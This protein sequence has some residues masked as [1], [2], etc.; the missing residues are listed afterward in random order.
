MNRKQNPNFYIALLLFLTII[1]S[2]L[3]VTAY[4]ASQKKTLSVSA[5]AAT[6]YVPETDDVLF[7][8]NQDLKLPMAS[9]TKIM[10][11]LVAIE[12]TS[13]DDMVRIDSS[14]VG[15]EGS[16]AYLQKGD[17]LTMEELLYALLLQ[18]ANDAAVA[19]ACYVGG[20]IDE[21]A[22]MMNEK[23]EKLE[24]KNTHFTNPH[25]LDDQ[26][27]YTTALE[28][29]IITGE[30]LKNPFFK[31]ITSTYKKTFITEDRTRTYVNHNK[32]LNKYEGAVGVKTGFTKKSG[33]CLVSAA[34]KDGLTL[35]SVTLDAPSDWND[36]TSMLD[37]GFEKIEKIYLVNAQDYKYEIPVIDG[38]YKYAKVSNPEELSI[39]VDKHEHQICEYVKLSRFTVAPVN[40]GDILGEIIYTVDGKYVGKANLIAEDTIK[41]TTK[42]FFKKH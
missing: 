18:S 12:N 9:T 4:S 38:E 14:A 22:E 7:E 16:S 40:K 33:R 8:K 41:K 19:I 3:S 39:I 17:V 5:K 27:H 2:L 35:I 32:L 1:I 25:G 24:L 11:A 30:A 28:L 42:G 29:A 21:F 36:H 10:T 31:Q 13:P 26:E 6:L 20:G 34:E 37:F 23:A 15:T